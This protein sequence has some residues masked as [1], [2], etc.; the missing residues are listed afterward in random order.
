MPR[1][2]KQENPLFDL[3]RSNQH[4]YEPD[5]IVQLFGQVDRRRVEALAGSLAAYIGTNLPGVIDRREGLAGY[6]TNPY[7]L[8]TCANVMRLEDPARFA[9]FLVNSKLY[10]GLET[11]FG[12]SIEAAFVGYY[13]INAPADGR[14]SDPPEKTAEAGA[15][16]GLTREQKARIRTQSVWREIDKS[17][18]IGGRRYLTMIKSGPNCI[19]DSQVQA[20]TAAIITHNHRWMEQTRITYPSAQ[21]LDLVIGI[22]YGTDRTTN[23]KE[24]QILIKLLEH[25]FL[26]EDRTGK[27]GTLIDQ[28]T[29]TIRVYRRIGRDFWSMIGN[30]AE[31]ES[32]A[33]VFLEV[34]LALAKAL[35]HGIQEADLES[36]IN[37]KI[38]ALSAAIGRMT[39]PRRSLP[40][41]VGE[42]FSD[43][44]LFW[45]ATALT[46]FYDEGI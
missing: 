22:T 17:C 38:Q 41:W 39:F 42:R 45:F 19:N 46:A 7:V 30:P 13:P 15:L 26:E 8:M 34:L 5:E 4:I 28:Q 35:S 9:Q 20:M 33:H 32:A 2:T 36:R 21:E 37:E 10:M 3:L 27:P 31:P 6:R 16:V 43:S 44:Q 12:K 1:H 24:N 11:S 40:A 29:R 18:M 25:G 14:W 23:N